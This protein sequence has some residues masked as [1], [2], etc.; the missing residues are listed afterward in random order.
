MKFQRSCYMSFDSQHNVGLLV[1]VVLIGSVLILLDFPLI[2]SI[3]SN[4]KK[5]PILYIT[6]PQQFIFAFN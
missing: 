6:S 4:L 2:F 1:I 5:F 3:Y